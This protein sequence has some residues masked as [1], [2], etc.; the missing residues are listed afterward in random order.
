LGSK[1]WK[2][3]YVIPFTAVHTLH[4][5]AAQLFTQVGLVPEHCHFYTTE[6]KC[7]QKNRPVP[8]TTVC[9]YGQGIS[10]LPL[11]FKVGVDDFSSTAEMEGLDFQ[12]YPPYQPTEAIDEIQRNILQHINDFTI[13][14][15]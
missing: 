4:Y 10:K 2:G 1:Y 11:K 9:I 6:G 12:V 14:K 8:A 7:I 3:E 15:E 5:V 13:S